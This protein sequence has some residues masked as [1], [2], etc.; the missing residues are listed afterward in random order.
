MEASF[1][2][3][4]FL[5][6]FILTLTLIHRLWKKEEEEATASN[7]LLPPGPWRIPVIGNLHQVGM[8]LISM[9]AHRVLGEL[10]KKH[11]SCPPGLTR[12]RV[13]E[14]PLAVVSSPE[15]AREFLRT[16][17]SAFAT[18]PEYVS[19]K[20]IFYGRSDVGFCPYGDHWRQMRRLCIAAL[21]LNSGAIRSVRRDEIRRLLLDVRSSSGQPLNLSDRILLL[22][23]SILCRSALGN[24]FTG[25]KELMV[26]VKNIFELVGQLDF[27]DVFPSWKILGLLFGNKRRMMR[28]HSQTDRIMKNI[29]RQ[30]RKRM[31]ESNNDCE[32]IEDEYH[33]DVLLRLMHYQTLQVPITHDNIKA[34][35]LDMF[36]GGSETS[37]I[38]VV[39]AMSEMMKNPK[40]LGRAQMEVREAFRFSGKDEEDGVLEE[41]E[42]G[43]RLPYLNSVVKETLRC[44]PP[45][46]LLLPREC[47]EETMVSG[48]YTIPRGT[49]VLVNVWAIARDP[50]YWVDPESFVPERFEKKSISFMGNSFEFLPFGSGRR[51][52][53]GIEAG[54]ANA[55]S[56]LAHLLFHFDWEFPPG[57]T[58]DSF[59]LTEKPGIAVGKKNRLFLIPTPRV[60]A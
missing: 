36:I 12:L 28:V 31:E 43:K 6:F 58:I 55:Q 9:P 13:G 14:I 57:I 16:H 44:H 33:V 35:I 49:Q 11:P 3:T 46:P 34:L 42:I 26:L 18:R 4:L 37:S 38:I 56:A 32:V 22:T 53:P 5:P 41:K 50:C 2:T 1:A 10:A 19:G 45:T 39:W 23:T 27:V 15:M 59:D 21:R 60:V 54:L 25:R 20:T 52:C 17:D 8:S 51:T 24:S 47:M 30:R 7:K 29:I 48:G 40:V